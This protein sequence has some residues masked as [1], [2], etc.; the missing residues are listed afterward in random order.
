MYLSSFIHFVWNPIVAENV[1]CQ[2]KILLYSITF[3]IAIL[4]LLSL[5]LSTSA[6]AWRTVCINSAVLVLH[7]PSLHIVIFNSKIWMLH[8]VILQQKRYLPENIH[9]LMR[10]VSNWTVMKILWPFSQTIW[11]L[12]VMIILFDKTL[13]HQKCHVMTKMWYFR[14]KKVNL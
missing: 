13:S 1:F 4:L 5:L 3:L 11:H 9:W 2:F 6:L 7:L 14:N 10:C 12:P 8:I